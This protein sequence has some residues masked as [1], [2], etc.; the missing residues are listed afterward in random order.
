MRWTEIILGVLTLL[1]GCAWLT[2]GFPP[3]RLGSVHASMALLSAWRRFVNFRKDKQEAGGIRADNRQKEMDLSKMYVDEFNL[4]IV[5]PLQQR[6]QK[7]ESQIERLHDAIEGLTIVDLCRDSA[8]PESE[9]SPLRSLLHRLTAALIGLSV[10]C[11]SSC[12]TTRRTAE[13]S[14]S[15]F[16]GSWTSQATGSSAKTRDTV[17][18]QVMVAVHDTIREVTTITVQLGE[19]GD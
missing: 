7:L 17:R 4:N 11:W 2:F 19:T 15:T 18:E 5:V 9:L 8:M 10:L 13:V 1:G 3:S 12:A 6:V 16:Q 14:S